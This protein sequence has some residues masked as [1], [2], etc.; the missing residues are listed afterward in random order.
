MC[1]KLE[2]SKRKVLLSLTLT[3][4]L[5]K[6]RRE[7]TPP[8][9]LWRQV[10]SE[11]R[12]WGMDE[13]TAVSSCF[14]ITLCLHREEVPFCTLIGSGVLPNSYVWLFLLQTFFYCPEIFLYTGR[15]IKD[16]WSSRKDWKA[17]ITLLNYWELRLSGVSCNDLAQDTCWAG[18]FSGGLAVKN[19]P[20]N[21]ENVGLIPGSGR[22]PG[23]GTGNP[24]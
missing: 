19:P 16:F 7:E 3:R 17:I 13:V 1:Y 15:Y 4:S 8:L 24:L 18:D 6:M 2:L 20:A 11:V 21:A 10:R 22:S 14:F 5:T 12:G 9:C 23:E